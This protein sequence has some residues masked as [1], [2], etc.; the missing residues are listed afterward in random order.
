MFV[1]CIEFTELSTIFFAADSLKL[2]FAIEGVVK[3]LYV[4][5]NLK[6]SR[7]NGHTPAFL[8]KVHI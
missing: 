3:K 4:G 7:I 1:K 2:V 6:H 5:R 8:L